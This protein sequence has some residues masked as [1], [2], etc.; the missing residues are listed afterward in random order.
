MRGD[1]SPP[2]IIPPGHT[3]MSTVHDKFYANKAE[4]SE[5]AAVHDDDDD[6]SS[7]QTTVKLEKRYTASTVSTINLLD[8]RVIPYPLIVRLLERICLERTELSSYSAA[9]LIFM[10][11]LQ[12]IRRLID[13]LSEHPEFGSEDAFKVYPLH[14]SLTSEEQSAV[15]DIP[16]SGIRK[17]VI[18]WYMPDRFTTFSQP[19]S[20]TNIAE[21]GVTIPGKHETI[22]E[23]IRGH[24]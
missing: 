17:I 15:F 24:T 22:W 1:A 4:W 14:S 3:N 13:M 6:S 8:E 21:T 12:E 10:P 20:A 11:G 19:I 16:P 5:D 9:I 2:N 7:E 18:G 23:I